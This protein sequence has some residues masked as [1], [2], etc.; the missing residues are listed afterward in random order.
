[1]IKTAELT[2]VVQF[3]KGLALL[4]QQLKVS[5]CQ[6]P[7]PVFSHGPGGQALFIHACC[8]FGCTVDHLP[9]RHASESHM[10][11]FILINTWECVYLLRPSGLHKIK[12]G[13]DTIR[14]R[15]SLSE[16]TSCSLLNGVQTLPLEGSIYHH[17]SINLWWF[18]LDAERITSMCNLLKL[19]EHL[20]QIQMFS[21]LST[22]A[23]SPLFSSWVHGS[24][25]KYAW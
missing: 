4:H 21:I 22:K 20:K 15:F 14:L 2:E 1:M 11:D 10:P 17:L 3:R 12:L 25:C 24:M 7:R 16:S 9:T 19:R 13:T 8:R 5:K 6:Y 18:L 23:T